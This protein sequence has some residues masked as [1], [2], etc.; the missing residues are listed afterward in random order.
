MLSSHRGYGKE[1]GAF[2]KP[3]GTMSLPEDGPKTM[4]KEVSTLV[5]TGAG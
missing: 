5:S 2:L 3:S 1:F 4:S